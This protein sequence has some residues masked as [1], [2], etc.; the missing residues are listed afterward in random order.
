MKKEILEGEELETV[1][2]IIKQ[3]DLTKFK[4]WHKAGGNLDAYLGYQNI[5]DRT[6]VNKGSFKIFKYLVKSGDCNLNAEDEDNQSTVLHTLFQQDKP[7]FFKVIKN[8][9]MDWAKENKWGD[10]PLGNHLK[11][12]DTEAGTVRMLIK[13]GAKI[14]EEIR[15]LPMNS[16][17]KV[18]IEK[19]WKAQEKHAKAVKKIGKYADLL[20]S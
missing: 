9:K 20:D 4:K 15:E 17:I 18:I 12:Y 2:E 19:A 11:G 10:T 7:E 13:N 16:K 6:T 8:E 14:T 1:S 3:D 5:L